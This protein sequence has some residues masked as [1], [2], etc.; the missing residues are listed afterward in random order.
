MLRRSRRVL[1]FLKTAPEDLCASVVTGG[2]E[3][4]LEPFDVRDGKKL[5]Q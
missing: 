3:K 4:L 2:G 1:I 5:Y